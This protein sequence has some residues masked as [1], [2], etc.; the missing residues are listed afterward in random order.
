VLLCV[1]EA[2]PVW[3]S[4]LLKQRLLSERHHKVLRRLLQLLAALPMAANSTY[5]NDNAQSSPAQQMSS[6]AAEQTSA[7]LANASVVT[8]A[9]RTAHGYNKH[10]VHAERAVREYEQIH[11]L[12][13]TTRH[14][15]VSREGLQCLGAAL[16]PVTAILTD[17]ARM[18]QMPAEPQASETQPIRQDP[19]QAQ[20]SVQHQMPP[21]SSSGQHQAQRSGSGNDQIISS[22]LELHQVR[23]PDSDPAQP[24]NP[25]PPGHEASDA[26]GPAGS[27]GALEQALDEM[28]DGFISLVSR[29][30]HAQQF[31]DIRLAAAAAL[32]A[33]GVQS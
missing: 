16:Q 21:H 12:V 27:E 22:R 24:A 15:S 32:E 6:S 2:L 26:S 17:V 3:L 30:S 10:A 23:G 1:G 5:H 29:S 19:Y 14:P 31:D 13:M 9:T 33:S 7:K 28:V 25:A 20:G 4:V 18:Q 11:R 8:A